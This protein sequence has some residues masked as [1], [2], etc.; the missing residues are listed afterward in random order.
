MN[1]GGN[2]TSNLFDVVH[3]IT[4]NEDTWRQIGNVR[5]GY[6]PISTVHNTVQL[7]YIGGVDRFQFEG[8]QYS[9]NFMQYESADGFL[10][11]SQINTTD[12]RNINQSINARLDVQPGLE[13]VQLGAD[14]GRRHVRDAARAQLL[15]SRA[16]PDADASDRD[17]RHGHRDGRQHHRIPRPVALHQRADHRAR[18]KARAVGRRARRPWQRE[19]R[20]RQVLHAS[21]ST[22]RAIASSSRSASS[23]PRSTRSSSARRTDSRATVRTTASAT[24]RSPAAA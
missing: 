6:S 18:R 15:R 7:T 21:R 19:R 13:V 12:S 17:E 14:V 24:S 3:S 4:N 10:G 8:N 9:P 20:S 22:R 2:G 11:T 16:R 23:R 5:L 1:G